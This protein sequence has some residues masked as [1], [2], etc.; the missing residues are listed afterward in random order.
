MV[1][2]EQIM[3]ELRNDYHV[4]DDINVI[5]TGGYSELISVESKYINIIEPDL[6][7]DGLRIIYERNKK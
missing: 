1:L 4:E 3:K 5:A 7:L 6:M 2:V